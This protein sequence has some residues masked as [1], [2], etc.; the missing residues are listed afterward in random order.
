V[1]QTIRTLLRTLRG[2]GDP[3]GE[4]AD[5]E[6][7]GRFAAR[8]DGAAFAALVGRHGPMVLGVCRRLL[9]DPHDAEDA[10]QATFLVLA[11]RAEA[12]RPA[13]PV[14][15]WLHGAA[16]RTA[17]HAR[18]DRARR[19]D[20]ERRARAMPAT[21]DPT[22]AALWEDVRPVLDEEIRRLPA[23]YRAP[24]VLCYLGG[25]TY[26]AA[27]REIGCPKGTVATRLAKARDLLRDRLTRRGVTL[28][29]AGLASI[30][31]NSGAAAPPADLVRTTVEAATTSAV[32]PAVDALTAEVLKAMTS[33][34]PRL[35][36]ARVAGLILVAA[37][38]AG[39]GLAL[40]PARGAL[41]DQPPA[42]KEVVPAAGT[43]GP[44]PRVDVFGDPLPAGAVARL[45]T[46]RLRHGEPV[47]T[48]AFSPDGKDVASGSSDG[49]IHVWDAATGKGRLRI[50]DPSDLGGGPFTGFDAVTLVA[51]S[52][53]GRHLAAARLNQRP[54]VWD[55]RTG[56]KVR[57]LGGPATRA[58]WL[59]F[60]PDGK[61]VGFREGGDRPG[62]VPTV[63][64]SEVTAGARATRVPDGTVLFP[65][66]KDQ[67]LHVP[68]GRGP[69]TVRRLSDGAEVRRFEGGDGAAEA[70]LSGDGRRLFVREAGGTIRAWDVATGKALVRFIGPGAGV[71][72]VVPAADGSAVLT[73]SGEASRI[74]LWDVGTGKRRWEAGT[75]PKRE[76]ITSAVVV[77]TGEVVTGHR[78]GDVRAWDGA[79]GRQSR[80]FRPQSGYEVRLALSPD[81]KTLATAVNYQYDLAVTL[82]DAATF[83]PKLPDRGHATRIRGI[84][85]R[86]DGTQVATG[87][88]DGTVRVW[89]ARTGRP[90]RKIE[91]P[92]TGAL[93]Y[94]PDGK[95]LFVAGA[96]DGRIRVYDPDGG[97]LVRESDAKSG[98]L[99]AVVVSA[100][101][102]TVVTAGSQVRAWAVDGKLVR[103]FEAPAMA[104]R[105][106]LSPD[107]ESVA[108]AG[109][110]GRLRVYGFRTGKK[111][112]EAAGPSEQ[113]GAIAFSPDGRLLAW[114]DG[115]HSIR[116]T[117]AATGREVATLRTKVDPLDCLT[118]S[119]D[120]KTLAWASTQSTKETRV[121]EVRTGQLRRSL[122][123][124]DG[125]PGAVAYSPDGSL[126]VTAGPDGAALVWDVHGREA[127]RQ[128]A[129]P[130]RLAGWWEDLSRPDATTG[131][132]AMTGLRAA[133]PAAVALIRDRLAP[134]PRPDAAR[135]LGWVADLDS[136][137]FRVR[138]RASRELERLGES[139][140]AALRTV[141]TAGKTE[142][143][144][145]R[146][147]RLLEGIEAGRLR[148]ERAVEVLEMIGDAAA[149]DV[150]AGLA[151][152]D[153]AAPLTRDAARAAKRLA[154]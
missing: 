116:L 65:A 121:W 3:A 27:A 67:F 40:L 137:A 85:F 91:S 112:F 135:L 141:E 10:F 1:S 102:R 59:R 147:R 12:V 134:V 2:A 14:G 81:G 5:A 123:G 151:G 117:D 51:F 124:H 127:P 97:T 83:E 99:R 70:V 146:A 66:N 111:V 110:D 133:G 31:A 45:G 100:D 145:A 125:P 90:V 77:P 131:Y 128:P 88:W 79:T 129:A 140:T 74:A 63:V 93:A 8:R 48:L 57:E 60:S 29:A 4:P 96:W 16:V 136:D 68:T 84:A 113:I 75:D 19:R 9:A 38:V 78:N 11:R 82:T 50:T 152:G 105:V 35:L 115:A 76:R 7:V 64:V 148:A 22:P 94:G 118:F 122:L 34:E 17:S 89:D 87:A 6:L 62:A 109:L 52:P 46:M 153:P 132:A 24:V 26:A 92:Y 106:A 23:A 41:P 15:A 55:V 139:A 21:T 54:A 58:S 130:A 114:S 47:Y 13:D 61:H 20:R 72:W 120:G 30:V 39:L 56:T 43:K 119:P 143:A 36:A 44:G 101:G 33:F 150:L 80:T 126:L 107:G 18:A 149:R 69:A 154:R 108:A 32:H 25:K 103:E 98:A 73:V 95:H 86:P 138:E 144:R 37:G 104:L 42:A 28:S 53:D 49:V 142:E 71:S